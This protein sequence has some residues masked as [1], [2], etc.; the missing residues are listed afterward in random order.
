MD[1]STRYRRQIVMN[2]IGVEGQRRILAGRV[3]V[4]GCGALGS[5]NAALLARAGVGH[6]TLVDRD[7]VRM[8]HLHRQVLFDEAD[9]QAC[10]PKA[11]AAANAI[12]R[13]N[14]EV[15]VRA[16]VADVDRTNCLDLVRGADVVVDG[17]DNYEMRA[18]VNEACVRLGVPYVHGAVL[19]AYGVQATL[20]P[21]R[22]AC[23]ACLI[24]ELPAPGSFPTCESAGV[25]GP[26]VALVASVQAAETL[27]VLGGHPERLRGTLRSWDLWTNEQAEV[28]MVRR[29]DCAVCGMGRYDFLE[30]RAGVRTEVLCGREAVQVRLA[31]AIESLETLAARLRA[32]FEVRSNAYLLQFEA[33]GLTVSVFPDGRAIVRGTADP[34]VARAV[35]ARCVGT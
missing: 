7:V 31:G 12:R 24:P 30:G 13:A 14:H 35:L 10:L 8:D 26:I 4:M 23:L 5:M 3:V 1:P 22:T 32:Q 16:V 34:A 28:R 21:R 27:K 11:V 20:I 15:R 19:G 17:A 18:L 6:L 33:D 9:A 29:A 2:E 25:L